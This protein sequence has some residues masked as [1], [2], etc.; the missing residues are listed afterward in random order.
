MENSIK[1]FISYSWTNQDHETWVLNLAKELAENGV[2]VLIDKWDLKEGQDSYAFMEKMV[3]DADV[4]KV[5]IISDKKYADKANERNGGVGTET[6]IISAEIY[7]N[8][9]QEKF[10]AAV[11]ERDERGEAYLPIYYKSRIYIDFCEP[12]NYAD[13]FEKLLRWIYDK[14][15][16]KR[17]ALGKKPAFLEEKDDIRLGT[18]F[19]YKRVLSGLKDSKPYSNGSIEEYLTAFSSNIEYFR[20]DGKSEEY[21]DKLIEKIDAFMPYRNEFIQVCIS[22]CQYSEDAKIDKFHRFFE[23]LIPYFKHQG[24]GSYY[25]YDFD[26]FKF[27]A[28]ELF[29]Y[30]VAILLKYERFVELDDFLE[31]DY[32]NCEDSYGSK[33]D[34]YLIFCNYLKSLENRNRRLKCQKLSLFSSIIRDRAKHLSIDYSYLMQ[35]D[36]VLF[37]RAEYG[38][39]DDWRRWCPFTLIYAEYI[40]KPLEIFFRAQSRKYFEKM[41]CVIGFESELELKAMIEE[42]YTNKREIPRWQHCTFSPKGL[43]NF[44]N[45]CSKK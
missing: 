8:Q 20:I 23:T 3:S 39:Q 9:Q 43:S 29:L 25:E 14:P 44:D 34:G 28:Y 4:Q 30:Y 35:A 6:Q 19:L 27:I 5:L 24:N 41:K 1:L 17:P 40:R 15:L 37:L 2:H 31:R 18:S 11:V 26:V 33:V 21:D 32:M 22:I 38:L 12:E 36:F 16:Y 42:Y 13:N 7:K 45:I 10:V